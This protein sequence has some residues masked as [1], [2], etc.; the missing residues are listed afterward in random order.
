M[1]QWKKVIASGSI[2][3]LNQLT[4]DGNLTLD[5]V[6]SGVDN[7]ILIWD[8][9]NVVKYDTVNP[10]VWDTEATLVTSSNGTNNE[11]AVYTGP[12]G[13]EGDSNLTW[14]GTQLKITGEVSSSFIGD[15][16]GLTGVVASSPAVLTDGA[17]IQDFSYDGGTA[18]IVSVDSGSIAINDLNG[19]LS[20]ANGG[21]GQSS[22][23]TNYGA[24]YID[25]GGSIKS[26]AAMTNGQIL[27]G[28][29]GANP[30]VAT[31]AEG[32]NISISNGTGKITISAT[33]ASAYDH[34]SYAGDDIGVDTTLLSGATVISD[35]DFNVTTDTLGHV[36]DAN[37]IV[38]TRELTP[39]DIGA[40]IDSATIT[41]T[42]TSGE[43]TVTNTGVAQNLS[44][45]P[46]FTIGL[47]STVNID[48]QLEVPSINAHDGTGAITIA[49]GTGDVE[50]RS[51]LS[52]SGDL[53][54]GGDVTIINTTNLLVEDKF[55]LLAS[56]SISNADAGIIVQNA[57]G[58]S[59]SALFWDAGTTRW[60]YNATSVAHDATSVIPEGYF[61]TVQ[62]GT[63]GPPAIDFGVGEMYIDTSDSGIWIYA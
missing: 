5:V 9:D 1:A 11:L 3:E 61:V 16:S 25:V 36:T 37:G 10:I 26:T 35:L 50:V 59:G 49:D 23:Y 22:A 41:L 14:N 29:T 4:L 48:T 43:T 6:Q 31:I 33:T 62:S 58:G 63:G 28:D 56:G 13:I 20:V 44:G 15:G 32:D 39:S 57:A 8:S 47:P 54:V 38:A 27:I 55:I 34:P 24:T 12:D 51:D 30:K 42:E 52:V 40:L 17:G 18:A 46:S 19:T 21:T 53:I 60:A 7:R 45:N 2:A